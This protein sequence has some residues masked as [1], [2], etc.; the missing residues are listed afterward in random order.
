M[1]GFA[2][3]VAGPSG[4]GVAVTAVPAAAPPPGVPPV[5]GPPRPPWWPAPQRRT[6]W[7]LLAACALT[8]LLA[9]ATLLDQRAG[10]PLTVLLL[11]AV[12]VVVLHRRGRAGLPGDRAALGL[13]GLLALVPSL[14]AEG[15][16]AAL[17]TAACLG[18][19]AMVSLERRAWSGLAAAPVLWAVSGFRGLAWLLRR[20]PV[21]VGAPAHP[22]AWA[23]GAAAGVVLVV[24]LVQLLAAA[25]PAF[26]R[27]VA[28]RVPDEL[29]PRLAL[30]VLAALMVLGLGVASLAPPSPERGTPRPSPS[31]AEWALPLLLADAVLLLFLI[32]QGAVLFDPE[33]ALAG[34]GVTPAQWARE[35]FGQ[36][37]A[38]TA[39][40]LLTLG[41]SARRVDRG[42]ARQVRLLLVGGGTMSLL[43]LAVVA[44][45]LSRMAFYTG[46]L[47][48][49]SMRLY[50][51][52]FE[53]WL[54]VVVVLVALT[55]LTRRSGLLPRAV[56]VTAGGAVL[57][58]ALVGP[59]ATA[60]SYNVDRFSR[61]G[62]LDLAYLQ[63]LS[64]DAV[65]AVARLPEPERSCVLTAMVGSPPDAWY[66]VNVARLRAAPV[67]DPA[68]LAAGATCPAAGSR[69]R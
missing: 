27:L 69:T 11:G 49:T 67:L 25:D 8:G 13:A 45:A 66:A 64:A 55:W 50:V 10:L 42:D 62:A 4:E 44:G 58:L 18:L 9:S 60:A 57:L 54:A 32:V 30:G 26:A 63:G 34:T 56:A 61:S 51:V 21:A 48:A 22:W 16:L 40:L 33:A 12:V 19:L 47:G 1:S 6:P 15:Q 39:L 3:P 38:V 36:L 41:W 59:D 53:V 29:G 17:G 68:G 28:L 65:P 14:R 31:A 52:V 20:P 37:V 43:V 2:G 24:V 23:R 7:S 35:G 46:Q 5:L